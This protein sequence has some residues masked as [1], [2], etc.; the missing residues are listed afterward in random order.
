MQDLFGELLDGAEGRE[1]KCSPRELEDVMALLFL[2]SYQQVPLM[3]ADAE[4]LIAGLFERIGLER[5]D[6]MD[7]LGALLEAY[8]VK[9]PLRQDVYAA[10]VEAMPKREQLSSARG[11]YAAAAA[12]R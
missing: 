2:R 8:F 6:Q 1:P 10:V 11:G 9:H 3:S 7:E 12:F 5:E 4:A